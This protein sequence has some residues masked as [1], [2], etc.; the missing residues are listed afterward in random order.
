MKNK[1][2]LNIIGDIDGK[3][4]AEAAP[5][6]KKHIAPTWAKWIAVAACLCLVIGAVLILPHLERKQPSVPSVEPTGGISISD[7]TTAKVRYATDEEVRNAASVGKWDSKLIHYTEEEMFSKKDMYIFRGVVSDLTNIVIDFE[8]AQDVRCIA[9]IDVTKV[10]KGD[11]PTGQP[12]KV[13]LPCAIYPDGETFME[14]TE[15]I[16]HIKVGM[17]G[18]FMPW[19][20]DEDSIWEMYNTTVLLSD[21]A[22]CGLADGIRWVFLDTLDH[23][24][25]YANF[26]YPGAGD[27]ML[28]DSIE[29]Y[30]IQKID[31]FTV[32]TT[33]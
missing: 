10:Y 5:E 17:E 33:T 22:P 4:I 7:K 23:G 30:I 15:V 3:H 9:T 26:A 19:V 13:L 32:T 31:Q 2:L 14:D 25:V 16:S 24:L 27:K 20:Y 28:L 12:I 6:T 29:E 1:R 21:L 18:I 11:I 8:F